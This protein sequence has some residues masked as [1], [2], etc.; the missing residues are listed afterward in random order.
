MLNNQLT[1]NSLFHDDEEAKKRREQIYVPLALVE[2]KKS[3]KR[4]QD[5]LS[6]EQGTKLYEPEYEEKQRFTHNT[7]LKEILQQKQ[8]KS[9]GQRISLI[10]EPGAGKTTLLQTI[11]NWIL[12]Q[13]LGL[14]V[15]VSL[16]D[17]TVDGNLRSLEDY[18]L[19]SWLPF[20]PD[21]RQKVQ[22]N[23]TEQFKAG[24][25][26]L[27]L[28]GVDEI[29]TSGSQTLQSIS[30]QLL[31]WVGKARVVLT[32]RL[33]VW[34]ADVNALSDFETFRL[35]DFDYPQQVHQF[36]DNWFESPQPFDP[37][38]PHLG[39]G[40]QEQALQ[41]FEKA[42]NSKGDRLKKE[43][44]KEEKGRVRDL[45]Q[46]PLRL[47]LLCWRWHF[48]EGS[49]PETKA[50][51]YREFV[52][53]FYQWKSNRFPIKESKRPELDRGLGRLA[54]DDLDSRGGHFRL[55]KDF[56]V[57][58]LGYADD[59][60]SLFYLAL[61]IGWLN[62]VGVAAESPTKKV[63]AFFHATF[64]EYFA[65]VAVDHWD[66][67]LPREH[68]NKPV[69]GRRYRIFEPQ[70]KQ[71]ILLWLG[72]EDVEEEEK[73]G[74]IQ[75]L[76]NF[77]DGCRN[78]FIKGFY[79]YR[80]YLIAADAIGELS[81][82]NK[83]NEIVPKM[84]DMGYNNHSEEIKAASTNVLLETQNLRST[85]DHYTRR[86]AAESLGKSNPGNEKAIDSLVH[87]L[88][89]T[90]DNYTRRKA[91][92]SLGIIGMGNEKAID[93]L[94][95]LLG[96]NFDQYTPKQAAQILG[97]IGTGNEK[98]IDGL[99]GL[100]EST[101][102]CWTRTEAAESLE[103]IGMGN[104]KAIDGL[105]HLLGPAANYPARI[106]AA[107]SLG[108]IGMG[109]E[110]AIDGLVHLLG[111]TSDYYTRIQAAESLG[112]IDPGNEKAINALLGLLES[113][114]DDHICKQV[115]ESLGKIDPGNEKEINALLRLLES[116][117][118]DHICRQVTE[119]LGK[120]GTYNH[121]AI[122]GLVQ[123][124]GSISDDHI[125]RQIAEIIEEICMG[126]QKAIDG[127][128]QFLGSTSDNYT[129]NIGAENLGKI[130][131]GSQKTID[132][133]VRFLGSTSDD[134]TRNMAALSLGKIGRG[135]HK[136][137]DSLVQFLGSTSDNYTR[138]MA[139]LSL[140]AI[141]EEEQMAKIVTS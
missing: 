84:L 79:K 71:I 56:I 94:L 82:Y 12:Q 100:L 116:T 45:V 31:G 108:K 48:Y 109:N 123:F 88:G 21:Q 1:S 69:K 33:N 106:Q 5:G 6:P 107:K 24:G 99:L 127:L 66:F 137:I 91:L 10:G 60:N 70:W 25:V 132:G 92:E 76:T 134:H 20:S 125:C 86:K 141:L 41:P 7:F 22:D 93:S 104:E 136:A 135:N 3:E 103:K 74:F 53:Y 122:D 98:A 121:K 34:Q 42:E 96:S 32:C 112:K 50:E 139:A 89:S 105:V 78:F 35:L 113:T 119:R 73:E 58:R 30:R 117:S 15:W 49:L 115:A 2:R 36:I 37:P 97:K 120:I 61:Q 83:T 110:K 19:N 59:E 52:E 130:S 23:F 46:N 80:A 85:S 40:E 39:R 13:E 14:P 87:L 44:A 43:L 131:K 128:V 63:Y 54:K 68:K 9:Q 72:R 140:G 124:L 55:R 75:V 114:S 47:V 26:W 90:S 16:A 17:L 38:Q 51:L 4:E 118:D 126:N 81:D 57:E 29:A 138:N 64:E 102:H 28:D 77:Q 67:F 129:R 11:G 95:G 133:L 62:N 101:Y 8:G 111:S 65:A 27:L 18:L